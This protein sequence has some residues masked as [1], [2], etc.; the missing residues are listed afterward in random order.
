M[1]ISHLDVIYGKV[2]AFTGVKPV[3]DIVGLVVDDH[4]FDHFLC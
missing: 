4:C 3:S 2:F 1:G